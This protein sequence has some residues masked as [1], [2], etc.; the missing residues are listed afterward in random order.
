MKCFLHVSCPRNQNL[1]FKYSWINKKITDKNYVGLTTNA[2]SPILWLHRD[3]N[4]YT[5]LI[6]Y[7]LS[8]NI[9][10][11]LFVYNVTPVSPY[12]G[13]INLGYR[14]LKTAFFDI[15]VYSLSLVIHAFISWTAIWMIFER[16]LQLCNPRNTT[17]LRYL[18]F[19]WRKERWYWYMYGY[20]LCRI[21]S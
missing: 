5:Y 13:S 4:Y 16:L 9:T 3:F 15:R 14:N 1:C 12:K 21:I 7:G 2:F 8:N 19:L 20:Q 6:F 18:S 11:L 10:T 17:W